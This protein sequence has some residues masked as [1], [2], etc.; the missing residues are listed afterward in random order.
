[1]IPP[2]PELSRR[3]LLVLAALATLAGL[4]TPVLAVEPATRLVVRGD[5]MGSSQASN[6]AVI[7]CF[8]DGVMR[9]VELMAVG[10]W[11]PEA[12]RLLREN[13][14]LDV[15]LHLTLTSEWDNVK[16]RP[17]TTAPSLVGRNGYFHPMI[18]PH[19]HYGKEGALKEQPW[20]LEEIE[21]EL[22]AQIELTKR[23]VPHLSHLSDHMGFQ[24]LGPEVAALVKRLAGEYGLDIDP[25]AL[26]TKWAGWNGKPETP[27]QKVESFVRV[28][29]GL[30]PGI[31]IFVDHPALDTPEMR[32]VSH[33]G[34]EAVAM[35]RQGVTDAWT[36]PAA[37]D[38]VNRR[39]IELIG[40]KDLVTPRDF[41]RPGPEGSAEIWRR[42]P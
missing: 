38:V 39:G 32:A 17:L 28:L 33:V 2:M 19:P 29:E 41:R 37:K 9:D 36:S 14:G 1:M 40:Y 31:W 42:Q 25:E 12:A 3:L 16:W 4:A 35:D 8:R 18:W 24:A 30:T 7:R 5:D 20:K 15:G 23:E 21:R 26:G 11:F 6:E 27:A 22:R 34:Y 10:P 13:P